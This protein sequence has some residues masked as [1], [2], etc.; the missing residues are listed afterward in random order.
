M[1]GLIA[2]VTGRALSTMWGHR[3]DTGRSSTARSSDRMNRPLEPS[4][5]PEALEQWDKLLLNLGASVERS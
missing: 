5:M 2:L 4:G 1:L 3:L